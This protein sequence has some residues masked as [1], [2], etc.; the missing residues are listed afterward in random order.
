MKRD[1][2]GALKNLTAR[3]SPREQVSPIH[4]G[5]LDANHLRSTSIVDP[6]TIKGDAR[7]LHAIFGIVSLGF[8]ILGL[9]T[10]AMTN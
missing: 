2:A 7:M 3:L 9:V 8:A 10:I 6:I 4:T 1:P 5:T